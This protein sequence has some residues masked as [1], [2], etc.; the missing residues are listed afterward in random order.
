MPTPGVSRRHSDDLISASH[1]EGVETLLSGFTACPGLFYATSAQD[2]ILSR[3]RIPGG[4]LNSQQCQAIAEI[5]DN[6]GGGYVDVTN[7]ANLQIREI[8]QGINNE[9][10]QQL[11]SLGLGSPNSAVDHIRNIM[12]SPTAGI[13]PAELIDTRPLVKS[14]DDYIAAH[15]ELSG[16]SAKFSVCFDGGGKVAVSDRLNDMLLKAELIDNQVYLRLHL[17]FIK[18]K[19]PIDTEIILLPEQCLSVLAALADVYLQHTDT[20]SKRKLRLQA[21]INSLGW[22]NYLQ[23]VE[24]QLTFALRRCEKFIPKPSLENQANSWHIGIH[25][26]RQQGLFYLG[27][28]LPLGRLESLQIRR[29]GDLAAKYGNGTI[30]L[31]PWQNLLITDIPQEWVVEVE[32]DIANLGLDSAVTNIKGALVACSGTRGCAASATDTK[33]HALVLADYLETRVRLDRPIN[34]HFSGCEKSCAQ[35][36]NGD[37][38]LLGVSYRHIESYH[39]Y[40]GDSETH[41]KFGRKIH[42]YISFAEL[43]ALIEQILKVYKIHRLNHDESFAEFVNRY[44]TTQLQELFSQPSAIYQCTLRETAKASI[45][46]VCN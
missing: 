6:Y 13:D 38:T 42:Q 17:S 46:A 37:I 44:K 26:Q 9:V 22:E 1:R 4:I 5:A 43:P 20:H 10:L 18:S 2:G 16:L 19:P 21:V 39:V 8:S 11:Q 35:H 7:R 45:S 27:V 34:I 24:Q 14:W 33:G 15:P 29:L 23:Q 31:T 3:L 30:R 28:V 12:T 32:S 41:A 40:V 36:H 25:P